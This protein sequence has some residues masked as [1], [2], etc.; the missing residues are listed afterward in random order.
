M[1]RY[2]GSL[3]SEQ[4][5]QQGVACGLSGMEEQQETGG[6]GGELICWEHGICHLFTK[7]TESL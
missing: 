7:A 6:G 1:V 4:S 2:V 3:V 5:I